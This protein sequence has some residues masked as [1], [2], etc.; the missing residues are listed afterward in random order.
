MR[1]RLKNPR[2][3]TWTH[4]GEPITSGFRA[5]VALP[6][7]LRIPEAY[8]PDEN[9]RL[10]IY[11]RFATIHDADAIMTLVQDVRDRH[12]APPPVLE[13]LAEH[14][15]IRVRAERLL[16]ASVEADSASVR[17][18]FSKETKVHPT[19]LMRLLKERG[20]SSFSPDGLLT[21]P[22]H[23]VAPI[24]AAWDLMRELG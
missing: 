8:V 4:K 20:G 10:S 9:Q 15:R 1:K 3:G 16:I 13:R 11:K 18:K 23:G 14:A 22:L 2:F 12:G 19:A 6:L 21:V 24:E 7:D 5:V 17:L